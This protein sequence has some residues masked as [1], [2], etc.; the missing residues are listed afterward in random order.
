MGDKR[1]QKQAPKDFL[2]KQA[3]RNAE[4]K[5]NYLQDDHEA[6]IGRDTW[7]TVQE[8]LNR[9]SEMKKSGLDNRGRNA[10]FFYGRIICGKCGSPYT[11]R[12]CRKYRRKDAEVAT[13]KSWTCADRHKGRKGNG[14]KNRNIRESVILE[15]IREK[16]GREN[17]LPE[18]VNIFVFEE[19]LVF[20]NM[21]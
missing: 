4:F 15:N 9:R 20:E 7:N 1:L 16:Y 11:R 10:H 13:Y 17:L 5:S 21:W 12:T 6:V 3:D 2:T 18:D 14:C 8:I 19:E